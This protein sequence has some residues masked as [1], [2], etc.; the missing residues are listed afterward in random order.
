MVNNKIYKTLSKRLIRETKLTEEDKAV[1]LAVS[2]MFEFLPELIYLDDEDKYDEIITYILTEFEKYDILKFTRA[3]FAELAYDVALKFDMKVDEEI[4]DFISP[5][6]K[7]PELYLYEHVL[8]DMEEVALEDLE[9]MLTLFDLIENFI[10]D[11]VGADADMLDKAFYRLMELVDSR[12]FGQLLNSDVAEMAYDIATEL[13]L[14]LSDGV[15][16][17]LKT[18]DTIQN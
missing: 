17:Y 15:L 1:N 7:Q 9:D 16:H 14:E 10:P 4:F 13:D 12:P 11:L 18:R 6:D 3:H 2:V 8:V 5:G